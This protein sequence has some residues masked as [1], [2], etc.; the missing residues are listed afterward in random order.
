[1]TK[2]PESDSHTERLPRFERGARWLFAGC[3]GLFVL[4]SL[5]FAEG[6]LLAR[7]KG[8]VDWPP[9][10]L[11][12]LVMGAIAVAVPYSR[13]R[14]I[15]AVRIGALVAICGVVTWVGGILIFLAIYMTAMSRFD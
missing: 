1:V 14:S 3:L 9:P 2:L 10:Y 12:G 6:G 5:L 8:L 15:K 11:L 7:V 4:E 13:M